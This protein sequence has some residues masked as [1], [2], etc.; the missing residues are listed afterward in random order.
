VTSN[1]TIVAC[2][3]PPGTGAIAAIGIRGPAAWDIARKLVRR[4]NSSQPA[5]PE[6]AKPS[7][8]WPGRLGG[9]MA[10]ECVVT[11]KRLAPIPYVEIHCH[12]GQEVVRFMLET[13]AQEGAVI[14]SWQRWQHDT[15]DEITA[16]A[17]V[18][19]AHAPTTRTAS[20]LLD[21]HQ[22]AFARHRDRLLAALDAGQSDVARQLLVELTRHVAVG[23]HLTEAWRVAVLGAPNV[24]KS[25]LVNALAGFQRSVVAPTPGTTR[26]VVT[27]LTA[28][29]GWPAELADT[30]GLRTDTDELEAEG[31]RRAE[32][33]AASADL[34]LWVLDASVPPVWPDFEHPGLHYIVNKCDLSPAGNTGERGA[35]NVSAL[36]GAGVPE[37]CEALGSWLVPDPPQPGAAVPF[38]AELCAACE[39]ALESVGAGDLVGATQALTSNVV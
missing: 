30:A 3:T 11:L 23:R 1:E 14:H 36:T 37:L 34:C 29:G 39:R 26:D 6:D 13:L 24:G 38:T 9:D 22:G 19:L 32:A 27:H 15:A 2:L 21:Q 5:L 4:R 20:I 25:S 7:H 12:G 16:L 35:L 10:D 8:F 33:T 17:A 18:A 31:I 28:F